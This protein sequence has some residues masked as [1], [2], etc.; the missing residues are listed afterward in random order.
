MHRTL[1][2]RAIGP[3]PFGRGPKRLTAIEVNCRPEA[4]PVGDHGLPVPARRTAGELCDGGNALRRGSGLIGSTLQAID[5]HPVQRIDSQ[6]SFQIRVGDR[7]V[8]DTLRKPRPWHDDPRTGHPPQT[9]RTCRQSLVRL[10]EKRVDGDAGGQGPDRRDHPHGAVGCTEN[11]HG[12]GS[13]GRIRTRGKV[14]H[15]TS[16]FVSVVL[17]KAVR[18]PPTIRSAMAL[19]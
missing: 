7:A 3:A 14:S 9:G 13:L 6:C 16:L 17:V 15:V 18:Q 2:P 12:G 10:P 4:D 8:R 11:I 19:A 1:P 5:I